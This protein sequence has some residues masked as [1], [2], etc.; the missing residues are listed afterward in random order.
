MKTEPVRNWHDFTRELGG[1]AIVA[2][3]AF[4]M[5]DSRIARPYLYQKYAATVAIAVINLAQPAAVNYIFSGI[6]GK[7][8]A[9][10][11]GAIGTLAVLMILARL[12]VYA[13]WRAHE[14]LYGPALQNINRNITEKF[15]AKSPHQHKELKGLNHESVAKGKA[16]LFDLYMD[17]VPDAAEVV[18]YILVAYAF[19]WLILPAAGAA[20]T[21]F[22]ALY[23][24][25][26][27]Y[28][29]YKVALI[30][31]AI[32]EAFTAFERYM[33]S[34]WRFAE[35]VIVSA[36]ERDEIGELNRRWLGIIPADREFW[37]W[38]LRHSTL[39][40]IGSVVAE[41]AVIVYGAKLVWSG[42]WSSVGLLYPLYAW[43]G[44]IVS[45][46]WRVSSI[47]RTVTGYL[48]TLTVMMQTLEVPPDVVESPHAITL[49]GSGPLTLSFENVSYRYGADTQDAGTIRNVSFR[50]GAGERVA[51]VGP[52]GAGKSTLHYLAL[53]FMEPHAGC[54]TA[55]GKDVRTLTL[56]SWRK[57]IA[58][59]PQKPQ[60]FDGT[61]RDN[62][63]YALPADERPEW[64]DEKLSALMRTLSIDFGRRPVDENPLNII[65]GREGVQLSGGQAQRLAIGAAVIKKPRLLLID[66]ATSHL[67]ST[68]EKAVLEGLRELVSGMTTLVIAH[69]LSTVQSADRTV[70]LVDGAV[71]ASAGTFRELSEHSATFRRLAADQNLAIL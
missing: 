40:D 9:R 43:T 31:P 32:E 5:A 62:L 20:L 69:R 38:H 55:N 58:Y 46:I 42:E 23:L 34:R 63:L 35:R 47:Q 29:N 57:A 4:R 64:T 59:I 27:L 19:L 3:W 65:V 49:N 7:D 21:L 71:E 11:G 70:V 44:V 45:N 17:H 54:I 37:L 18:S 33:V 28:L 6:V 39:R 14:H 13:L 2:R 25:W 26:S 66:E 56:H 10:I 48:P 41:L 61:V 50:V 15:L 51:L 12:G 1:I 68:T 67:D 8:I 36:K 22:I 52:S 16:K 24:S 53:R 60:I 30:C